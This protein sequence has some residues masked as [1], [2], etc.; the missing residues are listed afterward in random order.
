MA[1]HILIVDDSATDRA[2]LSAMVRS[3]GFE[4]SAAA[5][6]DEAFAMVDSQAPDLILMDVVMPG[7]SGYEATRQLSRDP[8]RSAIPVIIV[9]NRNKE[10]DKLWGLR[11]GA[12]AYLFKPVQAESLRQEIQRALGS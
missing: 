12:K 11:Q 3:L 6:A 4:A 2:A 10:T 8:R 5:S 1:K 9:S 7:A